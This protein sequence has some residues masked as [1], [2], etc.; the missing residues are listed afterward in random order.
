MCIYM[1]IYTGPIYIYV[2]VRMFC[3]Q[4]CFFVKLLGLYLNK[5]KRRM[6]NFFRHAF[7]EDQYVEF[8]KQTQNKVI[9]TKEETATVS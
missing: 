6:I 8:S 2:Y 9:G 1:Y 3:C 5:C 7:D 4:L